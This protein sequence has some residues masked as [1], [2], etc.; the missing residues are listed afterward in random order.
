VPSRRSRLNFDVM[1][2]AK[3][4]SK[5]LFWL[6]ARGKL[7]GELASAPVAKS[8][9]PA[10]SGSGHSD[11]ACLGSAGFV[12]SSVRSRPHGKAEACRQSHL[13]RG[14]ALDVLSAT[15]AEVPSILALHNRSLEWTSA[16]WPRYACSVFSA[17]RG[18]LAAAPQLER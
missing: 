1:Q 7:P 15:S 11:L 10:V 13:R 8:L 6:L 4:S 5:F 16:S 18:Q 12:P 3:Q 14:C 9:T 17:P 2:Q